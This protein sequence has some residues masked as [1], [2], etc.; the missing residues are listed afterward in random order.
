MKILKLIIL[1]ILLLV[2]LLPTSCSTWFTVN[3]VFGKTSYLN[4]EYVSSP[5]YQNNDEIGYYKD[6]CKKN[7]YG[8]RK[9][10]TDEEKLNNCID[11]ELRTQGIA[12]SF[13]EFNQIITLILL[14]IFC[15]Y[16]Y[17]YFR[18]LRKNYFRS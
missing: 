15:I 8:G 1:S 6:W 3:D 16:F 5:F 11:A 10:G 7:N 17:I 2:L 12:I 9:I 13:G 18:W 4:K 14:P